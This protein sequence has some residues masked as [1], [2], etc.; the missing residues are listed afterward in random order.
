MGRSVTL[1]WRANGGSIIAMLGIEDTAVIE[2]LLTHS[3]R[4]GET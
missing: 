1:P 4:K 3:E 2:L